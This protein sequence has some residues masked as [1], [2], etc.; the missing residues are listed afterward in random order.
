M[1]TPKERG[2]H[3]H[4]WKQGVLC[5]DDDRDGL[6]KRAFITQGTCVRWWD[7]GLVSCAPRWIYYLI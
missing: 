7:D 2:M 6:M 4:R 1:S 5:R 3:P